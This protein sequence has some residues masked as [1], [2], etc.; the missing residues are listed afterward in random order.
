MEGFFRFCKFFFCSTYKWKHWKNIKTW[1]NTVNLQKDFHI[2][3]MST[4]LDISNSLKF[5]YN[6]NN[7]GRT[8]LQ[9][10]DS[11]KVFF[12][13]MYLYA[14]LFANQCVFSAKKSI[15]GNWRNRMSENSRKCCDKYISRVFRIKSICSCRLH[16]RNW[17]QQKEN[18]LIN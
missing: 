16:L 3:I 5:E 8:K 17:Q 9:K 14:Y 6:E 15:I 2:S 1:L 4:I 18:C 13:N 10:L 12:D 11:L 7:K